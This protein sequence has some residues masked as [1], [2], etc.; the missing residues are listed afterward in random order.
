M[1]KSC[2]FLYIL[3]SV[4]T[5]RSNTQ[6]GFQEVCD[7]CIPSPAAQ[8]KSCLPWLLKSWDFPHPR[9][10]AIYRFQSTPNIK[11]SSLQLIRQYYYFHN[12][13]LQ[14]A[15]KV[16]HPWQ[17]IHVGELRFFLHFICRMMVLP[18][19]GS[20]FSTNS[21]WKWLQHV[22]HL[23]GM[24]DSSIEGSLQILFFFPVDDRCSC[25][26]SGLWGR[27]LRAD[28]VSVCVRVCLSRGERKGARCCLWGCSLCDSSLLLG[29]GLL[30]VSV[31]TRVQRWSKT[32]TQPPQPTQEPRSGPLNL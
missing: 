30:V 13:R 9:C 25:G 17:T 8:M 32:S 19:V 1:S 28:C 4:I 12:S 18:S 6:G 15:K 5:L 29:H 31:N 22:G 23:S 16:F 21:K 3:T 24:R 20:Y 2:F 10:S 7:L 27:S 14:V 26:W 11:W